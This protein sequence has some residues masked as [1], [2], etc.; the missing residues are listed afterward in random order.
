MKKCKISITARNTFQ[1]ASTLGLKN[2]DAI[3]MEFRARLNKKIVDL[4]KAKGIIDA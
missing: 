2:E 1:L 3:A 4:V